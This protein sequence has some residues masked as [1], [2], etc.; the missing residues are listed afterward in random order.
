MIQ[1]IVKMKMI[2]RKQGKLLVTHGGTAKVINSY[3]EGIDENGILPRVGI[4]KL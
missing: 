2:Y 4:R 3:F 1:L